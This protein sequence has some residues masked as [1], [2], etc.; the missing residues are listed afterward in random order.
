MKTIMKTTTTL[1][2]LVFLG[3]MGYS[4]TIDCSK[5]KNVTVYNPEFPSRSFVIKGAVQETY[6]NGELEMVWDLKWIGECEYE[7]ICRKKFGDS[8]VEVG[9]K[10]VVT[11]TGIDK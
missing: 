5:F 7:V 9:D 10:I 11:I 8:Q 2:L 1:I 6:T 3:S 4:Q